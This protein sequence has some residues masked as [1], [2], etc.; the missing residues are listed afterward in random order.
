MEQKS[1]IVIITYNSESFIE[2]CLESVAAQKYSQWFL[3][4]AD[5]NSEDHTVERIKKFRNSTPQ[6]SPNNFKLL[7]MRKNLGFS[8]GI[9]KACFGYMGQRLKS[10]SSIVFLNPDMYLEPE[11]IGQLT[12]PLEQSPEIG[13][14]GGL[15]LDYEG[16]SIQH[17]GGLISTNFITTHIGAGKSYGQL[18]DEYKETTGHVLDTV[19]DVSYV[20]GAMLATRARLFAGLGGFDTGYRPAYFEELDYCLKAARKG[21]RVVVNPLAIA[22][23]KQAATLEKFSN[24]FYSLYHKNRLRCAVINA[25]LPYRDFT[26]AET[27]WVRHQASGD[28]RKAL[29]SAYIK[30]LLLLGLNLMVRVKNHFILNRLKLK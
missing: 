16:Q 20:T 4:V 7:K 2:R 1:L 24:N 22:R 25:R 23:H 27:K 13:V 14:C 6:I 5:N 15:I 17:L 19:K 9:K 12:G 21:Y 8:G 18:R 30:N 28:Q 26:A 3:L 10:F 29:A 11:A